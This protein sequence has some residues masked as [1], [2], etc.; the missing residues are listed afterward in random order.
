MPYEFDF[1][2]DN[3]V[4]FSCRLR[5]NKCRGTTAAG[6]RCSRRVCIGTPLCFSH[7]AQR[8]NVRIQ[9]STIAGAGKGLFASN[10]ALPD[11]AIVFRRGDVIL[12]YKGELIEVRELERRYDEDDEEHVAPY[13]YQTESNRVID[14]ACSRGVASLINHSNRARTINCEF[15]YD[16]DDR[17]LYI[18]ATKNIKNGAELFVDY[19]P[20]YDEMDSDRVRHR[21]RSRGRVQR[22]YYKNR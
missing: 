17:K 10:S 15:D 13:G 5:C 19:G 7:L 9:P 4:L 12:E 3:D 11:N 16:G 18:V 21:T 8:Y 6:R 22:R 2:I 20:A 1:L 14:S